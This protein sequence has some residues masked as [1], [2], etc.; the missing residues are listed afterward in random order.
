[1]VNGVDYIELGI[2]CAEV[3][4][5][6]HRGTNGLQVVQLSPPILQAVERLVTWVDLG[7]P[8]LGCLL[9]NLSVVG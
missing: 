7:I 3:C 6:L 9:T 8:S 5:V 2:A 1:M 4:T